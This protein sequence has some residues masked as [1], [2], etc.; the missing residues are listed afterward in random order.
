MHKK[1]DGIVVKEY[2][3]IKPEIYEMYFI[4]EKVIKD[5]RGNIFHTFGHRFVYDTKL[6]I[7]ANNKE[8][9]LTNT[10]GY[11][12]FK[13]EFYGLI[14]KIKNA[15]KIALS[16][17]EIEI[18]D[19]LDSS[20]SDINICCYLK[21]P[22]PIMHREFLRITSQNPDYVKSV[23]IDRNNTFHFAYRKRIFYNQSNWNIHEIFQFIL[24][25]NKI[26]KVF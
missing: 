8:V 2:E 5:C 11:R 14:E 12:Y 15:D 19:K 22:I 21:L 13:C 25:V 26:S 4:L 7:I 24:N 3:N 18:N 10:R 17:S 23:C 16:F 1:V 20:L 6:T 9:N